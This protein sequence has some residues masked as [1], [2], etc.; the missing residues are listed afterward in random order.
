MNQNSSPSAEMTP[1]PATVDRPHAG[2]KRLVAASLIGTIFEFYDLIIYASVAGLLF[3]D[4]FFPEGDSFIGAIYVWS[5]FAISYLMRPIGAIVMGH[6]GDKIG[7]RFVLML[8][9]F[10][11]GGCTVLIGLLPTYHSIGVTAPVLMVILRLVQGLAAGGEHGSATVM[12][13]EHKNSSKHRGFYAA[14]PSAGSVVGALLATGTIAAL[15]AVMPAEAFA[16]WGWR[17]P[18]LASAVLVILGLIVRRGVSE[19]TA[20]KE[21]K[22]AGVT[23]KTPFFSL[24]TRYPK[25]M[26]IALGPTCVI[27]FVYYVS[28][29]VSIPYASSNGSTSESTLLSM[30]TIGQSIYAVAIVGFAALSDRIGRRILM[31]IGAIAVSGWIFAF[32]PLMLS[33][34]TVGA[35]V[36][37]TGLFV[38]VGCIYG[39]LPAFLSESFG[40][41]TRLTG[42]SFVYQSGGAIA[43]G[44][45]PLIATGLFGIFAG[46]WVPV[47]VVVVIGGAVTVMAAVISRE[48]SRTDLISNRDGLEATRT[49]IEPTERQTQGEL[50]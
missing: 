31:I 46:S 48:T 19:P 22:E 16:Q 43:G 6:F 18:F 35:F 1:P 30:S 21:A 45:A 25:Q 11:M 42:M 3:A 27:F 10:I 8:T 13:M 14:L 29:T 17:I 34:S 5:V 39:P 7:R 2:T 23:V 50:S 36:A 33:G 41:E 20:M 49:K 40:A 15:T 44:F 28:M 12:L 38:T 4:L 37:F 47:A 9:F 32:F 24:F 26:L